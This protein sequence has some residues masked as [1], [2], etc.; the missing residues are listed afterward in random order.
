MEKVKRKNT[1]TLIKFQSNKKFRNFYRDEIDTCCLLVTIFRK[2]WLEEI[3][4]Y[5]LAVNFW[6]FLSEVTVTSWCFLTEVY[7]RLAAVPSVFQIGARCRVG[8]VSAAFAT[9]FLFTPRIQTG[10]SNVVIVSPGTN[11]KEMNQF[12]SYY[13][14]KT[15]KTIFPIKLPLKNYKIKVYTAFFSQCTGIQFGTLFAQ[16]SIAYSHV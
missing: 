3:I 13:S 2:I 11:Y 10:I 8:A 1:Q 16:R 12:L 4:S 14:S 15:L 7:A 6:I 9:D 5:T